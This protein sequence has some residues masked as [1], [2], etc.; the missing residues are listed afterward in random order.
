[1]PVLL[2]PSLK[3]GNAADTIEA[4]LSIMIAVDANLQ[5]SR[6]LWVDREGGPRKRPIVDHNLNPPTCLFDTRLVQSR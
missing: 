6:A 5:G 3:K 4:L 1:M 2:S